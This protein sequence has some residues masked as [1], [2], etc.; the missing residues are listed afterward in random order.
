MNIL[1]LN[2]H[3]LRYFVDTIELKSLTLA[4]DRNHV[5]RPAV[6]QAIKRLEEAI[7]FDLLAHSKNRLQ[8]TSEGQAFYRKA[9]EALK[10][11][12]S[13]IGSDNSTSSLTIA[14]S[15][16]LAEY[17]VLPALQVMQQHSSRVR[18][19]VGTSARIKQ[20]VVDDEVELGIFVDD[21]R[22]SQLNTKSLREGVFRL[23]S[24]SGAFEDTLATTETRP[25][26]QR[27]QKLL[28]SAN[29]STLR[30][31]EFESWSVCRSAIIKSAAM[32]VLPDFM[33]D[34]NLKRVRGL[35]FEYPYRIVVASSTKQTTSLSAELIESLQK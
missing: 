11:F 20:L 15:A 9:K 2:L 35:A 5:S 17:F 6:S 1:D 28:K 25:E 13:A 19:K 18:L 14:C 16:S 27:L 7:G 22:H 21:E 4:A 33:A 3:G 29:K 31:L 24:A 30:H 32:G 12:E 10:A 34:T 26:V 23:Y 8:I